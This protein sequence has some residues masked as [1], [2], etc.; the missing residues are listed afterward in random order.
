MQ[1]IDS[2]H[3]GRGEAGQGLETEGLPARWLRGLQQGEARPAGRHLVGRARVA[4]RRPPGGGDSSRRDPGEA[5]GGGGSYAT[6]SPPVLPPAGL[7]PSLHSANTRISRSFSPLCFQTG[8]A[9]LTVTC[10]RVPGWRSEVSV[11]A[12]S[13]LRSPPPRSRV[14]GERPEGA[15]WPPGPGACGRVGSPA[16]GRCAV[17]GRRPWVPPSQRSG[18]APQP[19]LRAG[20]WSRPSPRLRPQGCLLTV[21]VPPGCVGPRGWEG[22]CPSSFTR[23]R[24]A[25]SSPGCRCPGGSPESPAALSAASSCRCLKR[26][27]LLLPRCPGVFYRKALGG[28]SVRKTSV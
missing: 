21:A 24:R 18:S 28:L 17:T 12:G 26:G 11:A 13:S 20:A 4:G 8:S 9:R 10:R 25:L 7:R 5:G 6:R 15:G 23:R 19:H 3:V 16:A 22:T 1:S 27:A 2:V 14:P